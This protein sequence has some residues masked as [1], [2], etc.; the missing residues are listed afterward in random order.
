MLFDLNQFL[1]EKPEAGLEFMICPFPAQNQ[2]IKTD[3]E[4][5]GKIDQEI[6]GIAMYAALSL[7]HM[8]MAVI[9]LCGQFLDRQTATFTQISDSE[10]NFCLIEIHKNSLLFVRFANRDCKKIL[11]NGSDPYCYIYCRI[12]VA[13]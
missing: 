4:V 11:T 5:L 9:Q 12:I 3:I 2:E 6:N 7:A 10:S 1:N 13:Q 8:A